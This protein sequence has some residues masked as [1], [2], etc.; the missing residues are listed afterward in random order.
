MDGKA[1]WAY[2]FTD[3]HGNQFLTKSNKVN[4]I[5]ISSFRARLSGIYSAL[6]EMKRLDA[7]TKYTVY[8]DNQVDIQRLNYPKKG[9]QVYHGA[10]TTF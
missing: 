1:T 3:I 4:A 2:N 7:E 9:N 8:C 6:I 5:H 10:I